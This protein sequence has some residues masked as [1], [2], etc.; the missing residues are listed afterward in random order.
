MRNGPSDTGHTILARDLTL[1]PDRTTQ[2]GLTVAVTSRNVCRDPVA[3]LA[4]SIEFDHD[5]T[6]WVRSYQSL[7]PSIYKI[8][9][10][11]GGPD[12]ILLAFSPITICWNEKPHVD[13]RRLYST[14][15]H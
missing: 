10:P 14:P 8:A 9:V 12:R 5:L 7:G 3:R 15:A 13:F 4:S 11:L 6:I 1:W 2:P